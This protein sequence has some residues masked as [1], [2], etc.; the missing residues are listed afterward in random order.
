[1][2]IGPAL[3]MR[4][5]AGPFPSDAVAAADPRFSIW[6]STATVNRGLVDIA[7]PDEGS[8]TY[9]SAVVATGPADATAN[10]PYPVVSLGDGGSA[11]LSFTIPFGDVPGPDFAVF[12]NGFSSGFLELAYVEVS[13]DGVSFYRFPATSLTPVSPNLGQGSAVDPTNVRNLAGKYVAG[14][15]TPFD[16]AELRLLYPALDTQRIIRVR[17]ID[18]IGT[19]DPVLASRDAGGRIVADPYPTPYTTGGFDLD[20]VGAFQATTTTYA[21]WLADQRIVNTAVNTAVNADPDHNGVQNGIEYL[22]GTGWVEIT[23]TTLHFSHLSYR[24]GGNLKLEASADCREW[25]TLAVSNNGA[26]MQTTSA[27]VVTESGD[28]RK[29]V[30][31]QL[32]PNGTYQFFRL[33][34]ELGL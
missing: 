19:N 2:I 12:E 15:G 34:A 27:A 4:V 30:S 24:T 1:M 28:F 14:L 32:P 18:A 16:L 33:A 22:T 6:A 21:S 3:I 5:F 23:G 7:Y 26:A 25:T 10:S 13:S 11:E 8:T 17:V 29:E 9:G 31:V 20:A